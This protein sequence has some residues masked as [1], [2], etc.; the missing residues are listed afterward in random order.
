MSFDREL[1]D[2]IGLKLGDSVTVN[3]LGRPV[4]ATVANLRKVDWQNLGIN[5][6]MVFS[7]NTFRGAPYMELATA[8]FPTDDPAR[9][10]ALA[11]DIA[12]SYPAVTT[13]RVRARAP[14]GRTATAS[15]SSRSRSMVSVSM[16]RPIG[17]KLMASVASAIP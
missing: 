11:R 8:G 2:G 13:V 5:F 7:P 15:C 17:A 10:T 12:Q 4:T 6:V 14:C 1:A 3:V 9:D 16:P